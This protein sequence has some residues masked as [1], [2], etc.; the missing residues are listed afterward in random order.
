MISKILN[1]IRWRIVLYSQINWIKTIYF[2]FRMFPFKI[3]KKLPMIF[4]GKV[5][6]QD[7]SGEII[8]NG[9][10]RTAMIGF[11]HQFEQAKKSKGIA[12]IALKGK[13]IF[14]GPT[15]LGKDVFLYIEKNAQ[16]EFGSM[17]TVGSDVKI[18]CTESIF[19]GDWTGIGYESQIIDT[20]SHPMMN[21]ETG[22][23]YPMTGS[24]KI[25]SHNACSNR[26]SIMVGTKTP[27]FCVIASNTICN[28]DYNFLG[29]NILIGGIPAKLLKNNYTRDWENEKPLL[30]IYKSI[31]L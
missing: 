30:K 1:S 6:F 2:N 5:S 4:F 10:I 27:D 31:S 29:N 15:N 12:E 13:L 25:G 19:I 16:L 18:V 26:V 21:S 24:I 14:N 22:E 3:G 8:I 20:N 7:L 11:G 23:Y 17:V 9:S 28:K